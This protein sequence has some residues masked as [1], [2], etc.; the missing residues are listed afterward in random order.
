M[1]IKNT[2]SSL[3]SFFSTASND[4]V[5]NS[6]DFLR[7][8]IDELVRKGKYEIRGCERGKQ[9]LPPSDADQ[10]DEVE[11]EIKTRFEGD[12]A[13]NHEILGEELS[14]FTSRVG[15]LQL[16]K[17]PNLQVEIN[18][19]TGEFKEEIANGLNAVRSTRRKFIEIKEAMDEFKRVNKR[20]DPAMYPDSK[21]LHF[22][23][24][25]V[26]LLV[27]TVL[28]GNMLGLGAEGGLIQGLLIAFTIAVVNVGLLGF[29]L[30]KGLRYCHHVSVTKKLFAGVI[31]TSGIIVVLLALNFMVAHYRDVLQS[32]DIAVEGVG[33][34]VM[35]RV[36]TLEM[37]ADAESVLLLLVGLLFGI[38][39]GIDWLKMDDRYPGYGERARRQ[40]LEEENY[41][42]EVRET[43]ERLGDLHSETADIL[44]ELK[45]NL[46]HKETEFKSIL[47]HRERK[48]GQFKA[49]EA[50]NV[51]AAH[52]AIERYRDANR[53]CRTTPAPDHFSREITIVTQPIETSS[54]G[55][56]SIP[57]VESEIKRVVEKL[58]SGITEIHDAWQ[59]AQEEFKRTDQ[60]AKEE[61]NVEG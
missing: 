44:L 39:A 52:Q 49:A 42:E 48:V 22:A 54:A 51:S 15:L 40:D 27:E 41:A 28:N 11:R 19:A 37:P 14:V 8:D 47:S 38:L 55:E 56:M 13:E 59:I 34:A 2:L 17:V 31:P 58:E 20:I 36:M 21:L 24:I 50:H 60:L 29:F 43:L 35:A 4:Y 5:Q 45:E 30:G 1:G 18:T 61:L 32:V 16:N 6:R 53:K 9:N 26:L 25:L 46:E 57:Q 3:K 10:L 7:V 33:S 12:L 23:F